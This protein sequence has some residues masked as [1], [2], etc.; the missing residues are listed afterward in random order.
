MTV[1]AEPPPNETGTEIHGDDAIAALADGLQIFGGPLRVQMMTLK[2]VQIEL[3]N[4]KVLITVKYR[5]K[6][7]NEFTVRLSRAWALVVLGRLQRLL[8]K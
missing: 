3:V 4:G 5:G 8:E 6:Q 1:K 2:D 7:T